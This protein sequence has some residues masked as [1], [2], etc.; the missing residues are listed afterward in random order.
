MTLV[1]RAIANVDVAG[2]DLLD[3]SPATRSDVGQTSGLGRL[4]ELVF[5]MAAGS[6]IIAIAFAAARY[7]RPWAGHLYWLG[8]VIIYASPAAFLLLR[9]RTYAIEAVGIAMLMPATT[10]LINQYYS[11]GQFRFLDEFEHVQTAQ[12]ILVTH[13][14]FH[15]NTI[16][17]Q[18]PQ[19]PGLEIITTSIVSI[20]HL[21]ITMAGLIVAGV[22]HVMF[23][24]VLYF[25]IVEVCAR[26]RVAAL[27]VVLYA[28]G[29]HYQFFDSYFIYETVAL[30]FLLLALLATVKMMKSRGRAVIFWGSAAVACGAVTAVCHH[31]T[32]YALVG[33][34]L[35]FVIA[36]LFV[37]S[38]ARSRGLPVVFLAVAA[39]VAI[40]D[41]G[42]ATTT[43]AYFQPVVN[44][45]IPVHAVATSRSGKTTIAGLP[46][47]DTLAEYIAFAILLALIPLGA[48]KMWHSRRSVSNGAALGLGVASLSL[49]VVLVLREVAGDGSEL[50]SRALTFTL[51]PV[52]FVGALVLVG[53]NVSQRSQPKHRKIVRGPVFLAGV[54]TLLVVGLAVGSI[55]GGWP[56]FFARLP[57]PFKV[58][59]WERS[60]D[61][62]NLDVAQ[63][64]ADSVPPDQG[65]AS[66]FS[67]EGIISA[68]G[69]QAEP[70]GV[71]K[72]FLPTS[73]TSSQGKIARNQ[74]ISFIVADRR[75]TQQLPATGYYFENDP[76]YGSYSTP[77]PSRSLTKFNDIPGV[78]RVYDDGTI[79]VYEIIGSQYFK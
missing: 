6:A 69:H 5:A 23:A 52:S 26:P 44:G 34:L 47:I 41:L 71:A 65:V 72:L 22:T 45:L 3:N 16:L 64:F 12:S 30:P 18:S 35:A 2:S 28:T 54:S 27:A 33:L 36:Q 67:T 50:A 14:L 39:I 53:R 9:K 24:I 48:W 38:A 57:G 13:H 31:V 10:F 74:R 75:I 42:V 29:S 1:Q 43:V 20:T 21:S 4:P 76:N 68:L 46:G 40:W 32:S 11:P 51:I 79:V 58:S 66:D 60:V 59:A 15:A 8:Q 73:Y 63:W 78:S 7:N 19:Y 77:L 62:H 56:S 25:L 70:T 61:H 49:F 17:P 37:P 55:A